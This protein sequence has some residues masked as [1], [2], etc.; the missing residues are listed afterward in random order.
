MKIDE[1]SVDHN[2]MRLID[3]LC[4]WDMCGKED[5]TIRTMAIG[6]IAGVTEMA[7]AMKEVLSV[8]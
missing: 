1:S 2:A 8:K 7:K 4:L 3:E 6:Y 5:D